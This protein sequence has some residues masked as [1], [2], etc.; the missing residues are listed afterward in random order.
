MVARDATTNGFG[1][2]FQKGSALVPKVSRE[3]VKLRSL[4]IL[5]D[6]ERRWFQKLDSMSSHSDAYVDDDVSSRFTIHELGGLFIIAGVA[7]AL[8]LTMHLFQM[9]QEILHALWES[10]LVA[11]LRSFTSFSR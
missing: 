3:I 10:G 5:K 11:K 4:G 2:M 9:P 8:V 1:F 6:M 7:H